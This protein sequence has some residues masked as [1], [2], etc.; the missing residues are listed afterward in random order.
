[1]AEGRADVNERRLGTAELKLEIARTRERLSR[2]LAA[3]DRDYALRHLAVRAA[4]LMRK[5]EIDLGTLG[6]T[7]RRDGPPLAVIGLG[8]GWL[9]L[10]GSGTGRDLLQRLGTALA[11]LQQLGREFGI[12]A[13]PAEPPSPPATLPPPEAGG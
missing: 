6:E 1:M 4:R 9:S 2:S 8:L 13:A 5:G 3:L 11:A 7:L 10:A 12:A